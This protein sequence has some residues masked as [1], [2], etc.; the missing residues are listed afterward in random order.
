M[1]LS[2][3]MVDSFIELY[4][5]VYGKTLERQDAYDRASRLLRLIKVVNSAYYSDRFR[6]IRERRGDF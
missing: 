5:K 6:H 1:K 4:Q 3:E 2:D